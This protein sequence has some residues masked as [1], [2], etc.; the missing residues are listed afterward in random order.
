MI[1]PQRVDPF[2]LTKMSHGLQSLVVLQYSCWNKWQTEERPLWYTFQFALQLNWDFI[3]YC[4]C[5]C[6]KEIYLNLR[7]VK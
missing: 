3:I 7:M 5:M 1:N 4:T 6:K 2:H